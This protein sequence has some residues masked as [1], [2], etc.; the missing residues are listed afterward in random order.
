MITR[1]KQKIR[2]KEMDDMLETDVY[3]YFSAFNFNLG[4][5]V[6]VYDF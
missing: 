3:E 4:R 6:M 1:S 5:R 2:K